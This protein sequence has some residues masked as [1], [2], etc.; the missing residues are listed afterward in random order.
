[1]EIHQ[2]NLLFI[3]SRSSLNKQGLAP[4][5]CRLTYKEQRKQFATGL[6][7]KP[8]HWQ[9]SKQRALPP[10]EENNFIHTQVSLIQKALFTFYSSKNSK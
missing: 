6:F 10:N 4:I 1:M 3:I 5:A 2:L 8:V 9:N 7:I